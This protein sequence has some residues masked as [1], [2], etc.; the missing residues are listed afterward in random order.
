MG[1]S[2]DYEAAVEEAQLLCEL[3]RRSWA[4]REYKTEVV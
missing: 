3:V 1:T 2:F 4:A